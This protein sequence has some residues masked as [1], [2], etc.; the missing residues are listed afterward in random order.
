MDNKTKFLELLNDDKEKKEITDELIKINEYKNYY[1]VCRTATSE[2]D[3]F[4]KET[5]DK[6]R[7]KI[8]VKDFYCADNENLNI[9]RYELLCTIERMIYNYICR[10]LTLNNKNNKSWR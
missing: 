8:I 3:K 4:I 2:M 6:Y 5:I 9:D 7:S 1:L 10:K